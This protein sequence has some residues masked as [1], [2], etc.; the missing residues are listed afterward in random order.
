MLI[1][2]HIARISHSSLA[3][4]RSS[5]FLGILILRDMGIF[6][7]DFVGRYLVEVDENE[8]GRRGQRL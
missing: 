2:R 7:S 6:D 3:W 4:L 1:G 8:V 5:T